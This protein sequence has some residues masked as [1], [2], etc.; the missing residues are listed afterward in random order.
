M[1]VDLA[2]IENWKPHQWNIPLMCN[3]QWLGQWLCMWWCQCNWGKTSWIVTL[4]KHKGMD[5]WISTESAGPSPLVA[6]YWYCTSLRHNI[7]II[8]ANLLPATQ[9]VRTLHITM[10]MCTLAAKSK[11]SL[12][13]GWNVTGLVESAFLWLQTNRIKTLKIFTTPPSLSH[14][15]PTVLR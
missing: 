6:K 12:F 2:E 3:R 4:F 5:R 8:S 15:N 1:I 9:P 11:T 10:D 13:V 7:L 14:D